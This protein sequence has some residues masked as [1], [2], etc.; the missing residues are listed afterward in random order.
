[1]KHRGAG[2]TGRERRRFGRARGE[3]ARA[4]HPSVVAREDTRSRG[5]EFGEEEATG[6]LR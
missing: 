5:E 6:R 4:F 3:A 1:V 2:A